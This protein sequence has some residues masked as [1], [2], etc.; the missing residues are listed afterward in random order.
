MT[1]DDDKTALVR[2]TKHELVLSSS[3]LVKRG[4][5]L[6]E[7]REPQKQRVRLVI[8][9]SPGN[10]NFGSLITRAAQLAGDYDVSAAYME[11]VDELM[12]HAQREKVDMF[13]LHVNNLTCGHSR[14]AVLQSITDL[15]RLYQRPIIA[16]CGALDYIGPEETMAAGADAFF[17]IP[18][19]IDALRESVKTLLTSSGFLP[20][21]DSP[22]T[23]AR[24]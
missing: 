11:N 5:D 17:E 18:F 20:R 12:H 13:V 10:Q 3:A 21:P 16:L 2:S 7:A 4:L 1:Q 22:P 15:R 6:I 24:P 19:S 23:T 8:G 9:S 14:E